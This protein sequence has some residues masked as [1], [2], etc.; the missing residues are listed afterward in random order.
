M[1]D[2]PDPKLPEDTNIDAIVDALIVKLEDMEDLGIT[3][4]T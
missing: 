1:N 3:Y 2:T 4:F